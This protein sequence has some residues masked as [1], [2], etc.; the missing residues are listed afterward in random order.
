MVYNGGNV[1]NFVT[2][3]AFGLLMM[4][5]VA[6]Y[7]L[8][9]ITKRRLRAQ[10]NISLRSTY[11]QKRFLRHLILQSTIPFLVVLLPITIILFIISM[12]IHG[13]NGRFR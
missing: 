1:V 2:F 12:E 5:V 3:P 10:T 7:V 13:Y 8:V 9:I 4:V 11:L 6:S